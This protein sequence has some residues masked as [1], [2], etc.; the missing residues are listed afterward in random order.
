MVLSTRRGPKR[1]AVARA[2]LSNRQVLLGRKE[3]PMHGQFSTSRNSVGVLFGSGPLLPPPPGYF[4]CVFFDSWSCC[5][6][7]WTLCPGRRQ[8]RHLPRNGMPLPLPSI[9]LTCLRHCKRL[10]CVNC[11]ALFTHPSVLP[12]TTVQGDLVSKWC[13]VLASMLV[14]ALARALTPGLGTLLTRTRHL[15]TIPVQSAARRLQQA[16]RHAMPGT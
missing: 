14:L 7:G 15:L 9:P 5:I 8:F 2:Y 6:T 1:Q 16:R 12:G 10:P 13:V 4:V 11:S 3:V